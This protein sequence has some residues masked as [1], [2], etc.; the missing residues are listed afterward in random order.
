MN[1]T[2]EL[3]PSNAYTVINL[4]NLHHENSEK[5]FSKISFFLIEFLSFS[6][7]LFESWRFIR[8]NE[9]TTYMFYLK[10]RPDASF[11]ELHSSSTLGKLD[12]VWM[13]GFGERGRLQ[14]NQLPKPVKD[15]LNK[16]ILYI[17]HKLDSINSNN[18]SWIFT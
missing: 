18:K 16:L 8:P 12:I 15:F 6:S 1:R 3:E 17:F 9:I 2:V 5:Y 14:T 4:N 11:E 10:A 13:S 7:S